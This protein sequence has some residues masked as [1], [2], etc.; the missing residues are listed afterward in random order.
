[1]VT[2]ERWEYKI[3]SYDRRDGSDERML[4]EYGRDG[5]QLVCVVPRPE[6]LMFGEFYFKRM[7]AY[8]F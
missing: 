1:M 3:V 8:D 4:R 5:W 2:P 6:S 7:D